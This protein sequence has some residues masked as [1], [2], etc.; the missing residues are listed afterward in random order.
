MYNRSA[1]GLGP[2]SQVEHQHALGFWEDMEETLWH[3][4]SKQT[5]T[6]TKQHEKPHAENFP[7]ANMFLSLPKV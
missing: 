3:Q 5:H 1:R 2:T 7:L 4:A 6:Q